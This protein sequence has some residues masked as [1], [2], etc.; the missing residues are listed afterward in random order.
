METKNNK[1]LYSYWVSVILFF[2]ISLP[3]DPF[4]GGL[5]AQSVPTDSI[6]QLIDQA[7]DQAER[8]ELSI[9]YAKALYKMN[10]DSSVQF[11][12]NLYTEVQDWA[13]TEEQTTIRM[14]LEDELGKQY[15]LARK[16][17]EGFNFWK[18]RYDELANDPEQDRFATVNGK[19]G[20]AFMRMRQLDSANYYLLKSLDL[21]ANSDDIF[22]KAETYR[23]L[24]AVAGRGRKSEQAIEYY[25]QA[26]D[27]FLSLED[28]MN[29]SHSMFQ[30]GVT[31][32]F[33]GQL[34]EALEVLLTGYSLAKKFPQY[35]IGKYTLDLMVDIYYALGDLT[36]AETYVAQQ[37]ENWKS[38]N[39]DER[40]ETLAKLEGEL[41]YIHQDYPSTIR[42]FNES[43]N[44][45][46]QKRFEEYTN[47][48]F[49]GDAYR[50]LNQLDSALIHFQ[51]GIEV[52]VR[53]V[54]TMSKAVGNA[55]IGEVQGL[56]GQVSEA[57]SSYRIAEIEAR[58]FNFVELEME[59]TEALSQLYKR[60]G[61]P[62]LALDYFER[63]TTIKDSL[64]NVKVV[65]DATRLT[66][67]HKFDQEK[68]I[69][70]FEQ[71]QE[72]LRQ[73]GIK[74]LL[75]L[76]LGFLALILGIGAYF[77]RTQ[78]KSNQQ[79]QDLNETLTEQKSLIER[80]KEKLEELDES[81]SRFFTNI[82]HEF[83]TPLTIIKGMIQ[84]VKEQP[85]V[86]LEKGT[87]MIQRNTDNVLNLV[88]QILDLRKLESKELKLNLQQS[89]VI[90][91]LKFV[92]ESHSSYAEQ[93]G[94]LLQ[95]KTASTKLVMD[96]D[97]EKLLRV[98]SNLL[99]NAIKFT[100]QGGEVHFELSEVQLKGETALQI[101]VKDTGI[102]IEPDQLDFVFNRFYQ[103][104]ETTIKTGEGT[105]IGLALCQEL[106]EL[107]DGEIS[108][109][110]EAG[111]G[112]VFTV[113]LPIRNQAPLQE[114][115]ARPTIKT[116][117]T[118]E[119]VSEVKL[120]SHSELA[121]NTNRPRVLI[122][123]DN[124]DVQQYMVAALSDYYEIDL[125][126]N[127]AIGIEKATESIP[128]LVISDVMMPEKDGYE[129][130]DTLKTDE[131][132]DHIPVILL[133]AKGDS[134]SKISGLQKGAD[135]Y[136]TKPFEERELL[137]RIDKLLELRKKL[138]ERYA[139]MP[140]SAEA[141]KVFQDPFLK[142]LYDFVEE[143][144]SDA[145]MNMDQISRAI[146]M[147]RTQVYR[148]L[149]ALTGKSATIFIRSIRLQKG[150]QL[151]QTTDLTASEVAYEVGFTS[152]S[153]FSTAFLE[154][155]GVRPSELR[156]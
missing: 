99:S 118:S 74:Q 62:R 145:E 48:I 81:K 51:N 112:S 129:L 27:L 32:F 123:E 26:A 140:S 103:A 42:L 11:L 73:Q 101:N 29:A 115:I 126:N 135:A 56:K 153:Y 13:Q 117:K 50:E 119:G 82:S 100:P 57:I 85:E 20:A 94:L 44:L 110:S 60:Q 12:A 58:Q 43:L 127:G 79:L 40:H 77:Y 128:D 120:N 83:R 55:R 147:S 35:P 156:K 53:Q 89:D 114:N 63:S 116:I 121:N 47:Y 23:D 45:S 92:L 64:F 86:H 17:E 15:R 9:A 25:H 54:F 130:T 104:D 22:R 6:Q 34:P 41:A 8:Y 137:V 142:K 150:K 36:A 109:Q 139:Q 87:E 31:H 80:Q 70:L 144:L 97:P 96:Y 134:D 152:L 10:R 113:L 33:A 69:L 67:Q 75:L 125:A 146:G 88:N 143:H 154:E 16:F 132:T 78:R 18:A 39:G 7:E 108:V 102:G 65:A 149:K 107:M 124:L 24:G 138:Q 59:I 21:Q 30:I 66:E 133:T 2:F 90:S 155:F 61:N 131:R 95:F 72:T 49:L 105:G 122:V 4:A 68:Q 3:G 37:L 38:Q 28:E 14:D 136:L 98:S 151:L 91:Y 93:Q 52:P 19:L 106:V 111:K 46:P 84:K 5:L 1:P 76:G 148:K 71:E 141:E